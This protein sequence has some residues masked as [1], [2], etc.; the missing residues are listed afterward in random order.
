[1]SHLRGPH[2]HVGHKVLVAGGIQDRVALL[3][4]REVGAADL[5]YNMYDMGIKEL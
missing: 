1:M 3:V 4:G 2:D 5:M